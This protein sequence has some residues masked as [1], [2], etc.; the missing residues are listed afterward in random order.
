MSKP[1]FY[2]DEIGDNGRQTICLYSDN[3]IMVRLT[4]E[5]GT[6][7]NV[8]VG[9]YEYLFYDGTLDGIYIR[10]GG[11][12]YSVSS[13][14]AFGALQLDDLI[15]EAREGEREAERAAAELRDDYYRGVL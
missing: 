14:I 7:W 3:G 11:E 15:E 1:S 8:D 10:F 6:I 4:Y 12:Y 13:L 9:G 5:A 2:I